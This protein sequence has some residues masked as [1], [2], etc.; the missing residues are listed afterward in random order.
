MLAGLL[1]PTSGQCRVD[2][3][4]PF[5]R[6]HAFRQRITLVTGNK[7]Q[8]LW[9]LPPADTF[10]LNRAVY[11]VPRA[12]YQRTLAELTELLDLSQVM[13]TRSMPATGGKR[14]RISSRARSTCSEFGS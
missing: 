12:Q 8:L 10:E 5:N 6:K 2:G 11:D 9:D 3:F 13:K 7:Q 1:F 4:D 14:P